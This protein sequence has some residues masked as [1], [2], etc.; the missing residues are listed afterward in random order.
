MWK[1]IAHKRWV[2]YV[3]NLRLLDILLLLLADQ[4]WDS[5]LH[6]TQGAFGMEGMLIEKFMCVCVTNKILASEEECSLE[7]EFDGEYKWE[8]FS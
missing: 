5:N 6:F 1:M 3:K 8:L 2:I 4:G 7:R